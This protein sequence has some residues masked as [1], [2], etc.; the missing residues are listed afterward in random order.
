MLKRTE[1]PVSETQMLEVK[2]RMKGEANIS[3]VN[4]G[5]GV[6]IMLPAIYVML[7]ETVSVMR[8]Q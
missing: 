3:L 6:A 4:S 5:G 2:W 1:P 8:L 7:S